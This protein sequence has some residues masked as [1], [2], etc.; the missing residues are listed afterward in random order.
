MYNNKYAT[1]TESNIILQAI[2][3]ENVSSINIDN[4]YTVTF[5]M[6]KEASLLHKFC[7]DINKMLWFSIE[8]IFSRN[9]F[10]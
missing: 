1:M 4:M 8:T 7:L 9:Y 5:I 3:G 2:R 6:S 10:K